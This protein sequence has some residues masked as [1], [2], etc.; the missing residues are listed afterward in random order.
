MTRTQS[1]SETIVQ[2]EYERKDRRRPWGVYLIPR[3]GSRGARGM[4]LGTASETREEAEVRR[5]RMLV[6]EAY[7]VRKS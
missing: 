6:P 7:E 3:E 2:G 1:W 4:V 5:S